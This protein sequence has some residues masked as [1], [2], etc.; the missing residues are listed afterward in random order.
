MERLRNNYTSINVVAREI[1]AVAPSKVI[2]RFYVGEEETIF[3]TL[4]QVAQL[5]PRL[6]RLTGAIAR[7]EAASVLTQSEDTPEAASTLRV[8]QEINLLPPLS[9]MKLMPK[10]LNEEGIF[11]LEHDLAGPLQWVVG[12]GKEVLPESYL[13][14]IEALK[15]FGKLR[16]RFSSISIEDNTRLLIPYSELLRKTSEQHILT[17]IQRALEDNIPFGN[18]EIYEARSVFREL[19]GLSPRKYA[20]NFP[21]LGTVREF[22]RDR[23]FYDKN[24]L[25]PVEVAFDP[26]S[27]DP[28]VYMDKGDIFRMLRNLL[29]DAVTHGE[30]PVIKPIIKIADSQDCAY[31]LIYSQGALEEKVLQLI[32]QHPYTTQDRISTPHGYGKVGARRLLEA[33]WHS[34]G[35]SRKKVEQLM[36]NLWMNTTYQGT[37]HVRWN[38]PL[39]YAS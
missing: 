9:E 18:Y 25:L 17:A 27:T 14:F 8:S 7:E 24:T 33:L 36:A 23:K 26:N 35:A 34:L 1:L 29:R 3:E 5:C 4:S 20:S 2:P 38:A 19:A 15:L 22:T 30:G 16:Y 32:G 21:L 6:R 28:V 37:P 12:Y 11:Q 31:L 39:P 10:P 13:R